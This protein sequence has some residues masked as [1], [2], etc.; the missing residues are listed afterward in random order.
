MSTDDASPRSPTDDRAPDGRA[1]GA[2]GDAHDG[3]RRLGRRTFVKGLGASAVGA[4]GLASSTES[5]DAFAITG[6]AAIGLAGLSAGA[7]GGAGL[8]YMMRDNLEGVLGDGENLSG[9]TGADA[10]MSRIHSQA[11]NMKSANERI[12]TTIENNLANSETVAYAKGKAAALGE[13]NADGSESA[14]ISAMESAVDSYYA[15]IQKNIVTHVDSQMSQTV[16]FLTMTDAHKNLT[17]T[18]RFNSHDYSYNMT[19]WGERTGSKTLVDGSTVEYTKIRTPKDGNGANYT[20]GMGEYNGFRVKSYGDMDSVD[21]IGTRTHSAFNKA[22]SR[23]STV[24]TK[25]EGFVTDLFS[26]YAP[27]DIP[28]EDVVDPVTAATQMGQDTGLAS[29]A[30]EAAMMGIPTS[31]SYSLW[32]ELQDGDG[33]TTEVEAEMYTNASPTDG[34]GNEIGW[35]VGTTYDPANFSEPIYIAYEYIDPESGEK[36]SDFMELDYPF[37]VIEA[38][39]SE[40]NEVNNIQNEER[41]TQTA[42]V[43]KLEEQLAQL[44]EEQ[45]RLQEQSQSGGGGLDLSA[46]SFAGIPGAVVAGGGALVAYLLTQDN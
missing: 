9:Y 18:D 19:G 46:L 2:D 32:L 31:A 34:S 4:A 37:T 40:G 43:S 41:I 38:T 5:A 15:T 29:Q 12:M 45:Q 10:L 13:M 14:A 24:K 44:R 21:F 26:Q 7:L 20:N 30:A 28:T 6:T 25:L 39:D 22:S 33:N 35:D 16:H 1:V 11:R 23:A 3:D 36:A 8:A 27:G 17:T 42:D